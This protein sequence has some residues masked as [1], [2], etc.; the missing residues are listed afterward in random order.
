MSARCLYYSPL[1]P[2]E[3]R[4]ISGFGVR[5]GRTSHLPTFHAGLDFGIPADRSEGEVPVYAVASGVVEHLPLDSARR[6]GFNGYGNAVVIRH[7]LTRDAGTWALYAHLFAHAPGLEEGATVS[8]G[9]LL[10]HVGRT[11]NDKFRGMHRHLHFEVRQA[12]SDGA[13]PFPGAYGPTRIPAGV[14]AVNIRR[15]NNIDPEV[16]LAE[17][18]IAFGYRGAIQ[19]TSTLACAPPST[20]LVS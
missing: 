7:T 15:G 6:G 14:D 9:T 18:G 20:P 19:F 4:L 17:R 13:S 16:W 3:G 12:R 11:T 8:A 10:G 1:A 2:S 5:P